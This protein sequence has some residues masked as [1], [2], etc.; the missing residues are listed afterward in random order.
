MDQTELLGVNKEYVSSFLLNAVILSLI[1]Y[2]IRF[3]IGTRH[4]V[5]YA[6]K[7]PSLKL[8][9]YHILGHVSLLFPHRLNKRNIDISPH[10]YDLLALIGYNSMFLKNK[11]SN[12]WQIY[13][14]F[15][16]I[17]HAD[18]VEVVLNHSTEL[19]KAWFYELLHPWIGTGLL[20]SNDEKWRVRRKMLTPAFHFNI[21]KDFLPVFNKQSKVLMGILENSTQEEFVDIVPLITKCSLDI[22][23]ES[24]LGKE[25]HT[26]TQPSSPYAKAVVNL[27]E[28]VFERMQR[29][30]LWNDFLFKISPFGRRFAKNVAT[31][32]DFTNKVKMGLFSN[33]ILIYM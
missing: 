32:H 7:L 6:N 24:I 20:T 27:T 15:I 17:Y 29:P 21:L 8:R 1:L 19:K 26:Q 31:V 18:T 28:L 23:C 22:I 12:I 13:Y 4:V 11:I 9:F 30:W 5:K 25:M 14:P 2:F 16:S 10:V 3:Y 33:I